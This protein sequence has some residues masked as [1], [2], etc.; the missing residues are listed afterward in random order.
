[1]PG[2]PGDM[3]WIRVGDVDL[4]E[5]ASCDGTWIEAASF[6]RLCAQREQQAIMVQKSVERAR[7]P[8]TCRRRPIGSGT[9]PVPSAAR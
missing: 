8:F 4:L 2:V 7:P 6:D 5:C 9:G 1:M 3:H